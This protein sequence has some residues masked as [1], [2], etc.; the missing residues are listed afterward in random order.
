MF[1]T[2]LGDKTVYLGTYNTYLTAGVSASSYVKE[3]NIDVS[4][5]PV[6][7]YELELQAV[8]GGNE[9]T[10]TEE[11]TITEP[12]TKLNVTEALAATEGSIIKVEGKVSAIK[13]A[14]YG[15]IEITDGTST[16]LVYCLSNSSG[17]TYKEWAE[18]DKLAVG[19]TIIVYGTRT[20]FTADWGKTEEVANCIFVS[21]EKAPAK[22]VI[23]GP[24]GTLAATISFA[25][26]AN[27]TSKTDEQQVWAQNG[28]TVTNDKDKSTTNV[29]DASNPVRFYANS[30]VTV[31]YTSAIKTIVFKTNN[32]HFAATFD[33]SDASV[34]VNGDTC[35]IVLLEASTSYSFSL[36]AQVRVDEI[37][38]YTE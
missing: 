36:P 16:I 17:V 4:Q 5:F 25:D 13:N 38:V 30:K 8:E 21:V 19:D 15:N 11:E 29:N 34:L 22:P 24:V 33:L 20:T 12:T 7:C 18:A 3:D 14:E 23:T 31:E 9:D 10:P 37:Q 27:R 28:V 26:V 35:T 1:T 2:T 6:R 32:K